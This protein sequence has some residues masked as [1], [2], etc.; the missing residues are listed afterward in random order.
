TPP[1]TTPPAAVAPAPKDAAKNSGD[2]K[3]KAFQDWLAGVREEGLRQGISAATLDS[4]LAG[5]TPIERIIQLDRRQPE[6]T[7]TFRAYI[8]ARVSHWRVNTGRER[9]RQHGDILK[10][11]GAKYGVQPRFVVALWGLETSF[12]R[13]TGGF[14]VV[15]A[16]A[17]LAF[18]GR[19]A[20]YFRREL[21]NAMKIID[22]GHISATA[23]KGSWAG[24][25]GQNQFMPSS[26]LSYAVDENGDG[27][28]DIWETTADVFASSANYLKQSGWRDDQTW[29]RE[30]LLPD[31][32]AAHLPEL[33][34][35]TPPRGCRDLRKLSVEKTLGEWSKLGVRAV[36]GG[37]LP[38]RAALK[39]SLALPEGPEGPALL[40]Y[41]N[42]RATMRWNCSVLFAAAVG[43]LADRLR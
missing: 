4:A 41:G 15:Q 30:V 32:F 3:I 34:P 14:S 27:R 33:M 35:K 39:A 20:A 5:L 43:M 16:L 9:L 24:A 13:A 6:F 36:G 28:R 38:T 2:E 10:Q 23:M 12:G 1:A 31:G 7:Q 18:D 17:T 29:G 8:D 21:F 37:P 22:A 11:I 40:V 42:F 26:F 25:M 19:R